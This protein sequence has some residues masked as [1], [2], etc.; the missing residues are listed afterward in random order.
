M[1]A[2][3]GCFAQMMHKCQAMLHT[4]AKNEKVGLKN[5]FKQ[6]LEQTRTNFN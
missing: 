3:S 5:I 4:I 2:L 1:T 6:K